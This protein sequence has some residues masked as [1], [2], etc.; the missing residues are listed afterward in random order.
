M[1]DLVENYNRCFV[2]IDDAS[3]IAS[4]QPHLGIEM[5]TLVVRDHGANVHPADMSAESLLGIY[6]Q[7]PASS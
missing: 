4:Q 1:F 6:L 2:S 3:A 7:V 5:I